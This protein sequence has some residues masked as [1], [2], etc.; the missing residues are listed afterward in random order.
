M[1]TYT[2]LHVCTLL[3]RPWE[4]AHMQHEEAMAKGGHH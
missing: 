4:Y 2:S 1:L 3:F